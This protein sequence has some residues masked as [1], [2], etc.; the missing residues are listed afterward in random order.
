MNS[1]TQWS[2][3]LCVICFVTF[4]NDHNNPQQKQH[5]SS[6]PWPN[7][8]TRSWAVPIIP[9]NDQ[10]A[11]TLSFQPFKTKQ[12]LLTDTQRANIQLGIVLYSVIV[13][14][15]LSKDHV[16]VRLSLIWSGLGHTAPTCVGLGAVTTRDTPPD[17]CTEIG[18][19]CPH[20]HMC[21]CSNFSPG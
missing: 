18:F 1:G 20:P 10:E 4:W 17:I 5:H 9:L 21:Y 2:L 12:E 3:L 15:V 6:A 19:F 7:Q 8:C 14:L 13:Q 16:R 11:R